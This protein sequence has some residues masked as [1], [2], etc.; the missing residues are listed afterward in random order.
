MCFFDLLMTLIFDFANRNW[1]TC[2]HCN[3]GRAQQ[4]T[5]LYC[6]CSYPHCIDLSA[7]LHEVPDAWTQVIPQIHEL[8]EPRQGVE[9]AVSLKQKI[10]KTVFSDL[11]FLRLKARAPAEPLPLALSPATHE[12]TPHQNIS[13]NP[14]GNTSHCNTPRGE[15]CKWGCLPLNTDL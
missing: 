5:G 13:A 12:S 9:R 15:E 6:G 3:Q 11:T 8:F 1:I 4:K 2:S 14:N 10:E 7:V